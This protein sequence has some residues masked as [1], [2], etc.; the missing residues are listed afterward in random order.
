MA[1]SVKRSEDDQL[2]RWL[3]LVE[4]FEDF[5]TRGGRSEAIRCR[6][7]FDDRQ[8]TAEEIQALEEAGQPVVTDNRIKPKV[9]FIMGVEATR[10]TDPKAFPREPSDEK[11]SSLAT[12]VLRYAADEADAD[13]AFST[14]F[15]FMNIEGIEA[16]IVV[17]DSATGDVVHQAIPFHRYLYDP[18]SQDRLFRDKKWDGVVAWMDEDDILTLW[19]EA[20]KSGILD[21]ENYESNTYLDDRPSSV[22]WYDV[23]RQR[24]RVFQLYVRERGVWKTGI[25]TKAGWLEKP[26]ESPWLDLKN[27]PS[28]PIVSGSAFIDSENIRYSIERQMLSPQDEINK[29]RSKALHWADSR[30]VAIQGQASRDEIEAIREEAHKA[31]GVLYTKNIDAKINVLDN[32][33]VTEA[34]LRFM[35][36]AIE[37]ID[38]SGPSPS[39]QGKDERLRSG[40]AIRANQESGILEL[41]RIFDTHNQIKKLVFEKYWERIK[42]FWTDRRVIRIVGPNDKLDFVELNQT[43]T[44]ED[45][46]R[47]QLGGIPSALETDPEYLVRKNEQVMINQVG[48]LNVDV[49]LDLVPDS[50]NLQEEMFDILA[51]SLQFMPPDRAALVTDLMLENMPFIDKDEVLKRLH[52]E[53]EDPEAIKAKEQQ[54]REAEVV[55]QLQ[56]REAVAKVEKTEAEADKAE[57][58]VQKTLVETEQAT[59]DLNQPDEAAA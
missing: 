2:D 23:E 59:K 53:S 7:Y 42:Q 58:E 19:P 30:Q 29:R 14:G 16:H 47:Q 9:M 20:E 4:S 8:W 43:L 31:D 13:Q 5:I 52:G 48:K 39:L 26:V 25:F 50:V 3:Q 28:N 41:T 1:D 27:R 18:H 24:Y 55:K 51:Q 32:P 45:A 46:V 34:Q 57:A 44:L 12:K 56:L 11:S 38:A 17:T 49:K 36:L 21:R 35:L 33:N 10:R 15:E 37:A 6:D 54:A 22:S 40:R